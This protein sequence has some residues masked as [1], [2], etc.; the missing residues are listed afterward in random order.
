MVFMVEAI[1]TATKVVTLGVSTSM[2]KV[3]KNK[4]LNRVAR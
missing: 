2:L 3:F 1:I 4:Y